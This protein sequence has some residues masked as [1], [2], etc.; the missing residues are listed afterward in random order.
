LKEIH[1]LALANSALESFVFPRC[2]RRIGRY[3]FK[4]SLLR[5]L[6]LRVAK[7][8]SIGQGAFRESGRLVVARFGGGFEMEEVAFDGAC[9]LAML[10]MCEFVS[11]GDY[12]FYTSG[13]YTDPFCGGDVGSS[14]RGNQSVEC[15]VLRGSRQNSLVRVRQ[16]SPSWTTV[17]QTMGHALAIH[18]LVR[19]EGLG[20]FGRAV[21]PLAAC[22]G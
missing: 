21:A 18:G 1:E 6:D 10:E 22:V 2:L 20:F 8:T 16:P 4:S 12:A 15:F 7:L 13:S 5:E 11:L 3:A 19:G 17:E 14:G 9:R